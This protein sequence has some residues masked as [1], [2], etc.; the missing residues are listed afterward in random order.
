MSKKPDLIHSQLRSTEEMKNKKLP[1]FN[2]KDNINAN[3]NKYKI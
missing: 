2:K 3:L 1:L